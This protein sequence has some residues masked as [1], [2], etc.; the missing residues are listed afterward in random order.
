MVKQLLGHP[1][2]EVVP[3]LMSMRITSHSEYTPHSD[4]PPLCPRR[5]CLL[6]FLGRKP[7]KEPERAKEGRRG[8]GEEGQEGGGPGQAKTG[9][10]EEEDSRSQLECSKTKAHSFL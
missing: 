7:G 4:I 1:P 10:G 6:H 2:A 9:G 3:R 8:Q 5:T